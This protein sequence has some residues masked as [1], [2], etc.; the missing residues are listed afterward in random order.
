M[1]EQVNISGFEFSQ[2]PYAY[3]NELRKTGSVH[4]LAATQTWLITGYKEIV[5]ALTDY[6]AFTS[7]GNNAFDPILLN[8]DPPAHT[9]HRKILS[10]DTAM[11]SHSRINDLAEAN[12]GLCK[13]LIN[14]LK[15]RNRF[16]LLGDFAMPFSSLIILNL[17]GVTADFAEEIKKWSNNAVL[18]KSIHNTLFANDEW[19]KL[20]PLLEL[21]IDKAAEEKKGLGLAELLFTRD[22]QGLFSKEEVLHLA[23]VLLLGGNETTP[24]LVSSALLF[25][26]RSDMLRKRVLTEPGCLQDVIFE[27]LRLEAPTQIIQRTTTRELTIGGKVI[28]MGATVG[29][30][31]GAANRD[32]GIFE[33]PDVFDADRPKGKILSFGYGPHYCIGANLAKQ[34]AQIAIEEL[35]HAFP[36]LCIDDDRGLV[37][38]H[39]SHV[40]GVNRL[41]VWKSKASP[42]LVDLAIQ[43]AA[44]VIKQSMLNYNEFPSFELY[45][46][47]DAGQWHYTYPSPFIH[48]NVLYSLLHSTLKTD[49]DLIK[50]ATDFLLQTKELSDTWRFWKIDNCRN[51]VPLDVDDISVCSFVLEQC[52]VKMSNK[53]L[54]YHNIKPN[55]EILTWIKPS[56]SLFVSDFALASS[57]YKQRKKIEPTIKAKMLSYADSE[58]GVMTNVLM[59]LGENEKTARTIAHC[60]NTWR[61]RSDHYFF[62]DKDIVIAYHIARAY[63]HGVAGFGVLGDEMETFIENGLNEYGFAE[64]NLAYLTLAYFKRTNKL[65]DIKERI[66]VII[67]RTDFDFE[68]YPYFTS[69]DRNFYGGSSGLTAAW[70]LEV[71]NCW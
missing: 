70:F 65:D 9:A 13:Q 3:Y 44:G 10:G 68:Q 48:A 61:N 7:Q 17:L 41:S 30:A 37:Y 39:S 35:L 5:E 2:D 53:P 26:L 36:D 14:N 8:S 58:L 60:I 64:L 34:E 25:I 59:Y 28:P 47:L 32:P 66:I 6:S 71:V 43:K 27:T 22:G 57:L 69:K 24:N 38:K 67:D 45:P 4:Y 16:E 40:R 19:K 15:G 31:I 49:T 46:K 42:G 55:G 1:S 50:Q 33:N 21:W 20:R 51:P 12:R 63:R 52:G 18:S 54:L 56:F 23:K 62:Y 29:L 11:F